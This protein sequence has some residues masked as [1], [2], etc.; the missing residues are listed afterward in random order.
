MIPPGAALIALAGPDVGQDPPVLFADE[1]EDVFSGALVWVAGTFAL[2]AIFSRLLNPLPPELSA[3]E[4]RRRVAE[5]RRQG[6]KVKKVRL[7]SGDVVVLK[8]RKGRR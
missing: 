7:S 2:L 5:L 4:S 1:S 6:Y 8:S 3:A